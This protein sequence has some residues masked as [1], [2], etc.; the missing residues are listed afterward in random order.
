MDLVGISVNE[1][2]S[3]Y[4]DGHGLVVVPASRQVR[5]FQTAK[6]FLFEHHD[7]LLK[8]LAK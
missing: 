2:V 6:E 4:A 3:V 8:R 5:D 1:P 7:G